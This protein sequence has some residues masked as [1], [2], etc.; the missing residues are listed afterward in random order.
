MT[1][2]A[3]RSARVFPA[4]NTTLLA[5]N[6]RL[7]EIR[8]G[9]VSLSY[10]LD[11]AQGYWP[12]LW[13]LIEY[14]RCTDMRVECDFKKYN[15]CPFS[16]FGALPRRCL[17]VLANNVRSCPDV[18][19]CDRVDDYRRVLFADRSAHRD[20]GCIAPS[21]N[22]RALDRTLIKAI[23][24]RGRTTPRLAQPPQADSFHALQW[25][26]EF[27]AGKPAS[28]LPDCDRGHGRAHYRA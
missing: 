6:D 19:P 23:L 5:F 26:R 27:L 24:T 17:I 2:L 11:C 16:C 10:R 25:Q 9:F 20:R 15:P 1:K 4:R 22:Q 21:H 13:M 3:N 8:R 7:H 14:C 18:A 12:D 28:S